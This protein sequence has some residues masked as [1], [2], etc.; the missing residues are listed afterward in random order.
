[1]TKAL[2][3]TESNINLLSIYPAIATL[4]GC[5]YGILSAKERARE[6]S[7]AGEGVVRD[8]EPHIHQLDAFSLSLL[9]LEIFF[10]V[11]K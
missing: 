7:E 8:R 10:T 1:M 9:T 3:L 2:L 6:L 4:M 5:D 11:Y